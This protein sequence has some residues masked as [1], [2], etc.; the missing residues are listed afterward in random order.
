MT[1]KLSI[2]SIGGSPEIYNRGQL[3]PHPLQSQPRH[4]STN[5]P[6]T[7]IPSPYILPHLHQQLTEHFLPDNM[8]RTS[9]SKR[10]SAKITA[11][12]YQMVGQLTLA[13][14]S[15]SRKCHPPHLTQLTFC[16]AGK[17]C[18]C[19]VHCV[20]GCLKLASSTAAA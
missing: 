12:R 9:T 11:S 16:L 3:T 7:I 8:S 10:T 18:I 15:H 2:R 1:C 6:S 19:Q 17:L 4:I 14:Q 20:P 5:I 13:S